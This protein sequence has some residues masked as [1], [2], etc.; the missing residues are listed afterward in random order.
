MAKG[1]PPHHTLRDEAA[2]YAHAL[3]VSLEF[4]AGQT[5]VG[6]VKV[7]RESRPRIARAEGVDPLLP[8]R[9]KLSQAVRAQLLFRRDTCEPLFAHAQ[10]S[11]S[12]AHGRDDF[13]RHRPV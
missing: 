7:G 11:S 12:N 10:P 2:G 9:G 5:V 13:T 8:Q 1:C 6:R 4:F 3:P